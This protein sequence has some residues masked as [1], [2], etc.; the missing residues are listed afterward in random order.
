MKKAGTNILKILIAALLVI[1]IGGYGWILADDSF[2]AGGITI[3]A[4][5]YGGPYYDVKTFSSSQLS[6]MAG[7][8]N[9]YTGVDSGG[10]MR[11]CHAWGVSF[12]KLISGAGI[13]ASSIR[14]VHMLTADN[15]GEG[16][17]TFTADKLMS[18]YKAYPKMT[19]CVS[20]DGGAT[21]QQIGDVPEGAT[22]GAKSVP[23]ILAL[24]YSS[25]SRSEIID[26]A[27]WKE[28][29]KEETYQEPV[30]K[31]REITVTKT[32]DIE[33]TDPETG[34]KHTEQEEY[35]ETEQEEYTDYEE[36]TRTV[37]VYEPDTPEYKSY[38]KGSLGASKGYR[39]IYG[40]TSI[41]DDNVG[42]S[43]H[44][45]NEI[46][47]QLAGAPNITAEKKLIS[48]KKGE[49]GSKYEINIKV[50][51][52]DSYSYL[53][54]DAIAKLQ[55]QILADIK[56]GSYDTSVLKVTKSED[57]KYIAEVIG[58]GDTDV[59][60][61]YSRSE[62]GGYRT[63]ASSSVNVYTDSDSDGDGD[64]KGDDDNDGDGDD[65]NDGNGSGKDKAKADKSAKSKSGTSL[66]LK[67]DNK[68]SQKKDTETAKKESTKSGSSAKWIAAD[69][70]IAAT[71]NNPLQ[72]DGDKGMKGVGTGAAGLLLAGFGGTLIVYRRR[73]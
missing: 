57:G 11:V 14:Y 1:C 51:M 29:T 22:S 25:W 67:K 54:A 56:K 21:Q 40:Q 8:V 48:G 71:D 72:T 5:F 10:F 13:D 44:S 19:Y 36:K 37:T 34:E 7:G 12:S 16:Y 47:I 31:T 23:T 73:L 60:F 33:V 6:S 4:G 20:R 24:G 35:T 17:T 61:T 2:A 69:Q 26:A 50:S 62:Y 27:Q 39:L 30:T 42:T 65:D 49:I 28:I 55:K 70:L 46:D 3:K 64:G 59:N 45:I 66:G 68:T 9:M 18:S 32:R 15:Y 41:K 38:S 58:E 52:P 63:N 43:D 53:S